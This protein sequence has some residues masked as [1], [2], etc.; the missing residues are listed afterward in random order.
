[1]KPIY[2]HHVIFI[3][4]TLAVL[5]VACNPDKKEPT[6]NCDTYRLRY[7][8]DI[9]YDGGQAFT[10]R[11]SVGYEDDGKLITRYTIYNADTFPSDYVKLNSKGQPIEYGNVPHPS[12]PTLRNDYFYQSD[13]VVERQYW[14]SISPGA[15][16]MLAQT[17]FFTYTNGLLSKVE[18]F[19]PNNPNPGAQ[20]EV[21]YEADSKARIYYYIALPSQQII[22]ANR[23]HFTNLVNPF[24]ALDI[25][26][27]W[28]NNNF[29]ADTIS[30]RQLDGTYAPDFF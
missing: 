22:Q 21:F 15:T 24:A 27:A 6:D 1:M 5:Q 19:E 23:F 16:I 12:S 25:G 20:M 9:R 26:F 10:N 4:I 3:C 8:T 30:S 7:I 29:L 17:S 13:Q 28:G 18:Y 14:S 2:H 11:Y